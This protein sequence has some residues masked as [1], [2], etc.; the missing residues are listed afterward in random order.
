[1]GSQN[2]AKLQLGEKEAASLHFGRPCPLL[3]FVLS[4]PG[5]Q[6]DIFGILF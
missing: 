5:E 6:G 3:P 4:M 1:M 2:M